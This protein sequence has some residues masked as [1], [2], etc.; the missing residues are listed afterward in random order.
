MTTAVSLLCT[1]IGL[2]LI[3]ALMLFGL[4]TWAAR[5]ARREAAERWR[6]YPTIE[7]DDL[8]AE[9]AASEVGY[10]RHEGHPHDHAA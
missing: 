7:Y 1:V 5:C 2:V 3:V 8:E 9:A 10:Y 4:S 6:Q